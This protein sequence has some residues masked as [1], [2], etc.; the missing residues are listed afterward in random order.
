MNDV[1]VANRVGRSVWVTWLFAALLAGWFAGIALAQDAKEAPPADPAA[2]PPPAAPAEEMVQSTNFLKYCYDASPAFFWI[3]LA[4]SVWMVALIVQGL[5][6]FQLAKIVPPALVNGLDGML[7][8]KKFKEAYELVRAD[9]SLFARSVTAGVERL[10]HGFDRGI[11]AMVTVSEDGK[12][13]MEH[14]ISHIATIGTVGPMLGLLGTVLGMILAFQQISQGGQPKPAELAANIGLALVSTLEGLIVA[15]PA[16]YFFALLR[17]R[18]T[19]LVFEVETV[20]ES[21]LWR[22]SS[23]LKK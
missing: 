2:N 9:P 19:R 1:G 12:M 10:S 17:N 7:N 16:I 20:G 6:R 21:Y 23:A 5:M 22:F 15:V 18:I 4:L 14:Q 3:M 13:D 11:D 8:E